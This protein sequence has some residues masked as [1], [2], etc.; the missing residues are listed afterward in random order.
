LLSPQKARSKKV[1]DRSTENGSTDA[2]KSGGF[3][4]GNMIIE[5]VKGGT[6]ELSKTKLTE[7]TG[8]IADP[9][10]LNL[11]AIRKTKGKYGQVL[12]YPCPGTVTA[13]NYPEAVETEFYPDTCTI[14]CRTFLPA[15]FAKILKAAGVRKTKPAK[16]V[17]RKGK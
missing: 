15:T 10:F 1:F 12:I 8:Y 14:G 9:Y 11:S 13:E 4:G 17:A 7:I 2:R 5:C 16:K 6:L 3:L